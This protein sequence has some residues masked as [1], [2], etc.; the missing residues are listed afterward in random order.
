LSAPTIGA[1]A[2]GQILKDL[3]I[4]G[5]RLILE[6]R[7]HNTW[8]NAVYTKALVNPKPAERWLLVTSAGHMPR[9]MG[10][11]RQAGFAVEPWPVDYRTADAWDLVRPFEAPSEGLKRLDQ[12]TREWVG[13]LAYWLTGRSDALFPGP[14]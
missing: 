7:S 12:V 3:G 8:Q 1:D 2:G 5:D 10:A 13:L 11:F 14:R 4:G 6:R 9:A